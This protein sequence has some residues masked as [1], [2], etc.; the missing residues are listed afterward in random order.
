MREY[1]ISD[2]QLVS[3]YKRGS[4][5]AFDTLLKR[6]NKKIFASIYLVVKDQYLAEDLLQEAFVKV[7]RIIKEGHYNEEGKFLPWILR[8]AR[9]MAI[10]YLRKNKRNPVI[11]TEDGSPIFKTMEFSEISQE[12]K[13]M[14]RETHLKLRDLVNELPD[15]QKNVLIMRHYMEMSFKEIAESTGININTALGRMRY[16]LTN[17]KRKMKQYNITYDY[18]FYPK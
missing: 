8:I 2:S 12:T 14:T 3:L 5:E 4:E 16:A 18:K 9:N 7:I 13:R 1:K 10:D 15:A 17:L 11:V 6:H